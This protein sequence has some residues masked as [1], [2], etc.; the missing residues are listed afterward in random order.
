MK[1]LI[2]NGADIN[3][4]NIDGDSSLTISCKLGY[5][6]IIKYLIESGADINIKDENG[7]SPLMIACRLK[8][9]DIIEYL[10]KSGAY[11]NI[12]NSD[13]DTPLIFSVYQEDYDISIIKYLYEN[14]ANI[15]LKND[16][17]ESFLNIIKG[18]F[19]ENDINEIKKILNQKRKDGETALTFACKTR[20]VEIIEDLIDFGV[21]VNIKNA[22]DE[23]ALMILCKN[24]YFDNE[25]KQEL[26]EKIIRK[27]G[28]INK[29]YKFG[30]TLLTMACYFVNEELVE[31][32][33]SK[34]EKINEYVNIRNIDGDTPLTIA[35][36]FNN[37]KIIKLLVE[38]GASINEE[39]DDK[40][41]PLIISK[42]LKNDEIIEYLEEKMNKN[43]NE[44]KFYLKF[45]F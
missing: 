10:V 42:S 9:K 35:C 19:N 14:G 21:D 41:N 45:Y 15:I 6:D 34:N 22:Y 3:T 31:Y 30:F 27:K 24:L 26:F 8:Y 37:E 7:E 18:K 40:E 29:V 2:E 13:M 1:N 17:G 28:N 33:L 12:L 36:Y 25:K 23:T 44:I 11:V 20:N 32:L 5:K 39:N 43:G 4:K 38:N 16:E